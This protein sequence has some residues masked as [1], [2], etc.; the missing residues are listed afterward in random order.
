MTTLTCLHLRD[1]LRIDDVARRREQWAVERNDIGLFPDLVLRDVLGAVAERLRV[2]Y[3]IVREYLAAETRHDSCEER[4]NLTRTDDTNGLAVDIK[5]QETS[6][7]EVEFASAVVGTMDVAVEGE[8]EG[9][10]VLGDG[11]RRVR[12]DAKDRDVELLGDLEVD[13]IEART[14]QEEYTRAAGMK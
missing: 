4:T 1:A 3:D 8:H 12:R 14:T 5:A 9:S 11:V 6:E 7:T 2:L 10:G 13:H